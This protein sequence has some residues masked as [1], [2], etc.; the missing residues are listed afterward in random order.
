MII[1]EDTSNAEYQIR[2]YQPGA[3]QVNETTYQRSIIVTAWKLITDWPPQSLDQLRQEDFEPIFAFKPEIVLL[4]TG[5]TFAKPKN[6]LLDVFYTSDV[7][8]EYMDTG[9]ACRTFTAL[10]AEGRHVVAALLIK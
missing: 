8:I 1:N 4:G 3:I 9:S 2:A 5:I 6:E 10:S 7:G